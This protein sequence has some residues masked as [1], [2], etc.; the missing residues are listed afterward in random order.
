MSIVNRVVSLVTGVE[1]SIAPCDST[2]VAIDLES[3]GELVEVFESIVCQLHIIT[4]LACE[5][6][7][8]DDVAYFRVQLWDLDDVKT[9]ESKISHSD[10]ARLIDEFVTIDLDVALEVANATSSL[11]AHQQ[12]D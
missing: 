2:G 1:P 8:H 11:I 5:Y 4:V 12:H 10:D 6:D 3:Y 9:I 7:C